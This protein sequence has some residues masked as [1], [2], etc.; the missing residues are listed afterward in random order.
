MPE[1]S[2]AGPASDGKCKHLN[3]GL[4]LLFLYLMIFFSYPCFMSFIKNC[5]DCYHRP[6]E[7]VELSYEDK[8][9]LYEICH[10]F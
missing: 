1:C 7:P 6:F 10:P 8:S 2:C 9:S 5:C 3:A 4:F